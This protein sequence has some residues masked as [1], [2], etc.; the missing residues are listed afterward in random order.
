MVLNSNQYYDGIIF[1]R[2]DCTLNAPLP[3]KKLRELSSETIIIPDEE[4]FLVCTLFYLFS[5]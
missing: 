3:I 2:P 1:I 4:H 5:E